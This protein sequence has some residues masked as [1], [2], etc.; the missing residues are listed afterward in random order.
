MSKTVC[1]WVLESM[2]KALK[3]EF[4]WFVLYSP[5]VVYNRM[6]WQLPLDY[7]DTEE[8]FITWG[9]SKLQGFVNLYVKIHPDLQRVIQRPTKVLK[10]AFVV[11]PATLG[12]SNTRHVDTDSDTCCAEQVSDLYHE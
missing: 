10:T 4:C 5:W 3:A 8:I 1:S 7:F 2:Y 6:D 12:E 9:F 11:G